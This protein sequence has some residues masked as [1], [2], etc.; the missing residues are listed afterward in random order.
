MIGLASWYLQRRRWRRGRSTAAASNNGTRNIPAGPPRWIRHRRRFVVIPLGRAERFRGRR[1]VRRGRGGRCPT[2]ARAAE[3]GNKRHRLVV[4]VVAVVV[5]VGRRDARPTPRTPARAR[6]DGGGDTARARI[7]GIGAGQVGS[8]HDTGRETRAGLVVRT[9]RGR[10]RARAV[11]LPERRRKDV[12]VRTREAGGGGGE[13][14]GGRRRR[15]VGRG[16]RAKR[17]RRRT[18]E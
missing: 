15:C 3:R 1:G 13:G 6:V 16:K 11:A 9:A 7:V 12:P 8:R 2:P 17:R 18:P 10:D 5:V 14:G 4:V